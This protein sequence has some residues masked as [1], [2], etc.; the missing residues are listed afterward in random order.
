MLFNNPY[1]LTNYISSFQANLGLN[2]KAK[3]VWS[4]SEFLENRGTLKRR[5]GTY[6]IYNSFDGKVYIGSA[7]DLSV[8]VRN[9]FKYPTARTTN[10]HMQNTLLKYGTVRFFL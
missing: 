6:G 10:Q 1:F 5:G 9:H 2:R 7:I 3:F 8:R 4:Y